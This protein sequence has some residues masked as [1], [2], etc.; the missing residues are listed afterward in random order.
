MSEP[1]PTI[2]LSLPIEGMSCASCVGRIEIALR[3]VEGVASV[4]VN[5]A[6]GRAEIR[7]DPA[8]D[9]VMLARAVEAAGYA[10]PATTVELAVEGMSCASCVARVE[11]AL[12]A[13][14]FD[15]T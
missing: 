8:V 2:S 4:A 6:T 3:K 11:R 14:Q 10:V 12:K 5:L 7:A 1:T 15:I 9:R 13:R